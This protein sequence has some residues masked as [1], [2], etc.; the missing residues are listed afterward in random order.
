MSLCSA[1]SL[2][3]LAG[4]SRG[5]LFCLVSLVISFSWSC[6]GAVQSHRQLDFVTRQH[7]RQQVMASS[8][9]FSSLLDETTRLLERTL[10]HS[11]FNLL[12]VAFQDF[13]CHRYQSMHCNF[14]HLLWRLPSLGQNFDANKLQEHNYSWTLHQG[15]CSWHPCCFTAVSDTRHL[16]QEFCEEPWSCSR[17]CKVLDRT[18]RWY[19]DDLWFI[20]FI[21]TF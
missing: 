11:S 12:H 15:I 1:F 13:L 18:F 19:L 8:C 2:L 4:Q 7:V 20:W 17:R 16:H 6:G 9:K 3:S 14:I 10:V 5:S 21:S